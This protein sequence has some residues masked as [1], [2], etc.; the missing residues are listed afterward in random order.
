MVRCRLAAGRGWAGGRLWGRFCAL[1]R[2]R[3]TRVGADRSWP[4]CRQRPRRSAQRSCPCRLRPIPP[5]SS[6]RSNRSHPFVSFYFLRFRLSVSLSLPFL[7]F[8]L[9]RFFLVFLFLL[10][11]PSRSNLLLLS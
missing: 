1:L 11:H 7:S 6:R 2:H 10:F 9:L 3:S 5:R 8:L 4:R